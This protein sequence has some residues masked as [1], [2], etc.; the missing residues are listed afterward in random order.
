MDAKIII[1]ANLGD[2]G[3]GTIVAKYVKQAA[4]QSKK[5]INVLTNGGSQR[6]HSILTENGESFTFK[7][8]G[9]GTYHGAGNYFSKHFILNPMQFVKEYND[10]VSRGVLLHGIFRNYDCMWTTPFDMMA[11][12]IIEEIR[13]SSK[14]GSCGMGIWE[15]IQRYNNSLTITL[16]G[17]NNFNNDIKRLHLKHIKDYHEKRIT[18]PDKWKDVW[19]SDNLIDNFIE[20]CKFMVY[21]T[22]VVYSDNEAICNSIY[23]EVIFENG[24][25]LMLS[26]TGKDI[27]GTTPSITDSSYAMNIIRNLSAEVGVSLHYVTRPYLTRHGNGYL[28][29]E[30]I[31]SDVSKYIESDRTNVYNQFQGSFRYAPLDLTSLKERIISDAGNNDFVLEVTHCDE[32][33][34]V[35]EFNKMF[36]NVRITDSAKI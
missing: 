13:G 4:M 10:L 21:N 29:K 27:P 18:I 17:F 14:H 24:Q 22:S 1:G 32:M 25:G 6:A 28:R 3:K 33:D 31:R 12:Q 23:D 2:E 16:D 20:D 30:S 36:N 26:D 15:T 11:N 5:V 35:A 34:R 8:F 9:S 19:N 7:H